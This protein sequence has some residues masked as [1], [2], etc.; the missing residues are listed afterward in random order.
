MNALQRMARA[1]GPRLV[2]LTLLVTPRVAALLV[3]RAFAASGAETARALVR[4]APVGVDEILDERYDEGDADALLDVFRPGG[5]V[6][7]LPAVVWIHGGAWVGGSKEELADYFKLIAS[8]GFAVVALR[9]SLAPEKRYPTPVRQVMQALRH[10]QAHAV[11]LGVDPDRLF[12]AGDSAGAQIGAQVAAIVTDPAYAR[13][14]GVPSTIEPARLRGVV[15]ACGAYDLALA[16]GSTAAGGRFLKTVLWAYSGRRRFL[17]DPGFAL[18]AVADHV[19]SAFPPAFITAG[20]AD[21]LE[22]HSRTLAERLVAAGTDVD[23]L[24]FPAE[25]EPPLGHEYQFDLDSEAGRLAHDRIVAFL[26][27]RTAA[28]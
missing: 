21:P 11:R 10:V 9:Y 16:S 8:G 12:I 23:A 15:L 3:R 27:A 5:A 6:G 1:A 7:A 22:P 20:N 26:R 24:F 14:V 13:A 4:H 19:T 2:R 25:H 28:S 17:D 18:M